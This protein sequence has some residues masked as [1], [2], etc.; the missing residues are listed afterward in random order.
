MQ[1]FLG[2]LAGNFRKYLM[3]YVDIY[4]VYMGCLIVFRK[5]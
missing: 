1:G 2:M 5:S 3:V 4:T